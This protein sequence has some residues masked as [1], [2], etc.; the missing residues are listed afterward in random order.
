MI[1]SKVLLAAAAAV[2]GMMFAAPAVTTATPLAP[3]SSPAQIA[4]VAKEQGGIE[5][6]ASKKK[7]KKQRYAKRY[8]KQRYG[9]RYG[10]RYGKRWAYNR[11][12]FRN[13][14]WAYRPYYRYRPYGYAYG[15]YPYSCG[16]YGY[17]WG[18]PCYNPYWS[19]GIGFGIIIH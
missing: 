2:A 3:I 1:Q 17:S 15:G 4:G 16:Y 11:R 13:R 7:W 18:S 8:G 6:V 10:K 19:P 14:N 12:N 5:Q 9:Q